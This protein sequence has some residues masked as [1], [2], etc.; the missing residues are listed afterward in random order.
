MGVEQ[1]KLEKRT[2]SDTIVITN[3]KGH[4]QQKKSFESNLDNYI[5]K[6]VTIEN[7]K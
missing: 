1:T 4:L 2:A 7:S 5:L 6:E 3:N